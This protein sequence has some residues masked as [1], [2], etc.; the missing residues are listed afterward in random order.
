MPTLNHKDREDPM[1]FLYRESA[2]ELRNMLRC[3]NL[4]YIGPETLPRDGKT[5]ITH[6]SDGMVVISAAATPAVFY[7]LL[8]ND[9]E[10]SSGTGEEMLELFITMLKH[11][12]EGML[13]INAIKPE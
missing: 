11:I 12:E 5:A 10:L 2:R 1:E 9:V 4:P 13:E 3:A 8:Y 6:S 7:S